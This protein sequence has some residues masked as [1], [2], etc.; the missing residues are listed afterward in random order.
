MPPRLQVTC[1]GPAW[2]TMPANVQAGQP[3]DRRRT[4]RAALLTSYETPD[5]AVLVED[6][7]PESLGLERPFAE[8]SGD[9]RYLFFTEL[10]RG[11]KALKGNLS[12][13]CSANLASE[14]GKQAYPWLFRYMRCYGVGK[15]GPATQHAKL[16]LLHWASYEDE[17]EALE[18]VVSS[19]NL[20]HDALRGQM[21]AGW[22][23][24]IP[25]GA[26]SAG[27]QQRWGILP[28]FLDE[29]GRASATD[30]SSV[31][32]R[33]IGLLSRAEAPEGTLK[34]WIFRC[35]LA[36]D[37]TPPRGFPSCR[38]GG[39]D[40]LAGPGPNGQPARCAVARGSAGAK[41][42]NRPM[43]GRR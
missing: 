35:R 18:I 21:Q 36:L 10:D 31:V 5:S 7:L 34:A 38:A 26:P 22:R 37:P 6:L 2:E 27:R 13:F 12:V 32:K 9:A 43:P 11:L 17:E 20:T 33:W 30:A 25:L 28:D 16:W 3:G 40:R 4:L 15:T 8:E 1:D 24:V 41:A 14:H 19:C 29:L 23:A 42:G 39:R